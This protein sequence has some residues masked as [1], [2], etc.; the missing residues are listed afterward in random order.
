[1]SARENRYLTVAS[2]VVLNELIEYVLVKLDPHFEKANHKAIATSGVRTAE[3]QLG[4]IR[5]FLRQRGLDKKYPEAMVGP[6][7]NKLANGQYAWQMGWSALLNA[8]IIINPPLRAELLMDYIG[9]DGTNKKGKTFEQTQHANGLCLDIGGG[10]DGLTNEV[11]IIKEAS[12]HI[13]EI[14]SW[15]VEH[16]NNCLHLNLRKI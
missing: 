4:L 12:M 3:E 11:E 10:T 15:V 8:G 1:M 13:P 5:K 9:A 16:N 6:V 7:T 2:G 14:V